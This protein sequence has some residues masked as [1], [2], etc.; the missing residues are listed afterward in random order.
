MVLDKVPMKMMWMSACQQLQL[1]NRTLHISQIKNA[2]ENFVLLLDHFYRQV[3]RL[4]EHICVCSFE[5][6]YEK[7]LNAPLF[8]S[9][10]KINNLWLSLLGANETSENF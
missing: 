9:T 10:R 1:K 8:G 2:D 6:K 4:R 7:P 3:R 5:R